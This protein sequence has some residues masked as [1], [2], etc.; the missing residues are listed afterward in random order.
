MKKIKIQKSNDLNNENEGDKKSELSQKS[1]SKKSSL[2]NEEDKKS[3]I[4]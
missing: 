4:V 1:Q 2:L 3:K